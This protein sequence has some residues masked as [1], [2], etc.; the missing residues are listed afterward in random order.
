MIEKDIDIDNTTE[1]FLRDL[2]GQ[3]MADI[4]EFAEREE[5]EIIKTK[6]KVAKDNILDISEED[7]L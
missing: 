7:L 5:K 4:E 1:E 3:N 2:L 6:T